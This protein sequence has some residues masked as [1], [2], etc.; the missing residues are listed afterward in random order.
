MIEAFLFKIVFMDIKKKKKK[1][2]IKNQYLPRNL[3]YY[4][5]FKI[6]L[7]IPGNHLNYYFFKIVKMIT[8]TLQLILA[9]N[10]KTHFYLYN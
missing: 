10:S 1:N 2:T 3:K 4:Y 6:A 7:K 5:F 8:H 9:N